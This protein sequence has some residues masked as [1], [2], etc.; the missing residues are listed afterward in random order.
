LVFS[1]SK[2][3]KQS[4]NFAIISIAVSNAYGMLISNHLTGYQQ[5]AASMHQNC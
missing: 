4:E 5:L 1:L 2:I 3:K